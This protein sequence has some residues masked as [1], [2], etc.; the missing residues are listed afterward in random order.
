MLDTALEMSECRFILPPWRNAENIKCRDIF[1]ILVDEGRA[2]AECFP[3]PL[4][5]RIRNMWNFQKTEDT[6]GHHLIVG[7]LEKR[8]TAGFVEVTDT[9]FANFQ[10]FRRLPFELLSG[11]KE[12]R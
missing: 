2:D 3:T 11:E 5:D 4:H 10:Y 1:R 12:D 9:I 6:R 8:T 7:L